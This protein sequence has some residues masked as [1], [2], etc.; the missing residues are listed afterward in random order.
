MAI[1]Q[2]LGICT[3]AAQVSSCKTGEFKDASGRDVK[4]GKITVWQD[5]DED[6]TFKASIKTEQI[7]N[8][9]KQ[10]QGNGFYQIDFYIK[11]KDGKADDMKVIGLKKIGEIQKAA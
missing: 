1:P 7:D 4:Y 3:M 11:V 10:F 5:D 8:V 2:N 9:Q 6:P